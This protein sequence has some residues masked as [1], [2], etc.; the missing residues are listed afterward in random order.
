MSIG[1]GL[2]TYVV[3]RELDQVD[4][5]AKRHLL[6]SIKQCAKPANPVTLYR[7]L[8][9]YRFECIRTQTG[10]LINHSLKLMQGQYAS[11]P[12]L[13]CGISLFFWVFGIYVNN[14][15]G[16]M[17]V[18]AHFKLAW[19]VAYPPVLTTAGVGQGPG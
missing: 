6:I 14:G 11:V 12:R 17:S 5:Q 8:R 2:Q 13:T 16:S 15:V 18:T 4:F 9:G 10:F 1:H 7:H 3:F 19:D